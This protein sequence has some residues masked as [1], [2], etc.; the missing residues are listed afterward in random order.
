MQSAPL[1]A[2]PIAPQLLSDLPADP[3]RHL[4]CMLDVK[5]RACAAATCRAC[6][7]AMEGVQKS[8][9]VCHGASVMLSCQSLPA[10]V[11]MHSPDGR[12]SLAFTRDGDA[13]L[14][15]AL[16]SG[17]ARW[18]LQAAESLEYRLPRGRCE[19]ERLLCLPLGESAGPPTT[20]LL[21]GGAARLSAEGQLCFRMSE[22]APLRHQVLGPRS[23]TLPMP[24]AASKAPFALH[25]LDDGGVAIE[26]P[27]RARRV[28]AVGLLAA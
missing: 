8:Q 2:Q 24:P 10:G 17:D 22:Q 3:L 23:W 5:S 20:N 1:F 26:G 25:V 19:G 15:A 28:A 14:R 7:D 27:R 13:L 4:L 12:T 9:L 6:R 16:P 21:A 18:T 11:E